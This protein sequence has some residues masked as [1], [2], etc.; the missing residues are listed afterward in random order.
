MSARSNLSTTF[1][2]Q[3]RQQKRNFKEPRE[4]IWKEKRK[5]REDGTGYEAPDLN[6]AMFEEYYK[7]QQ[8]VPEG[9]WDAFM[10]CLRRPLP[11]TFR[12]NGGGKFAADLRDHLDTAFFAKLRQGPITVRP[13]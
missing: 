1:V 10:A 11:T 2:S 9:E 8:I 7:R 3:K 5:A 12:I 6:N 13:I 4:D